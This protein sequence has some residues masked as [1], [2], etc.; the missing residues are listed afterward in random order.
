MVPSGNL[1][2]LK[3]H[4]LT[5]RIRKNIK[6]LD[7]LTTLNS[8]LG[9]IIIIKDIDD[10]NLGF[11]DGTGQFGNLVLF[12]EIDK[13]YSNSMLLRVAPALI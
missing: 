4:D 1:Q 2:L 9:I 12:D 3:T 6:L 7:P 11:W 10:S 8:V 5:L 13:I